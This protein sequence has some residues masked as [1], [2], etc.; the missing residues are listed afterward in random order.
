MSTSDRLALR[1]LRAADSA[2]T[3]LYGWR[4]NPLHQSGALAVIL[5]ALLIGTGLFLLFFY[6]VSQPWASVAVLQGQPWFGRWMRSLHRVAS[7]AL[8]LAVIVHA[9]R[10][11]AQQRA[12]GPRALAWTSGVVLLGIVFVS[13]WTGYVLV[14]DSFGARLAVSGAQLFDALPV[15]SEPT[16]RIFAG[17]EPVPAAF[18]FINLFLHIALPLGA[19][20]GLWIHLSRLARPTLAPPRT[21][22]I[23][24]VGALT[25]LAVLL[26]LP[27]DG[28]AALLTVPASVS[29][30]AFYA[31]WMPWAD[32]LSP[33]W[34]WTGALLTLGLA[35]AVP[36]FTRR[37]REGAWAPSVV[38]PKLCT[39]C[40]QCPVDCPWD[41]ITMQPRADGRAGLV[42]QVDPARCVSCGICAGSCAPMGVGPLLRSG[43]DQLVA[44]RR[45]LAATTETTSARHVA[46][47]CEHAAPAHL[48]PLRALGADVR[49]VP[50]AGNVHSSVV[51]FELRAGA[52]GVILYS[53]APRDCRGREGPKWLHERMYNGREAELQPRVDI[54]RVTS[55]VMAPGDLEGTLDAYR[56]F[57]GLPVASDVLRPLWRAVAIAAAVIALLLLRAGTLMPVAG[58]AGVAVAGDHAVLRLSWSARPERIEQCRRLSDEEFNALPAHMR[59]RWSCEGR[60]AS[61]LLSARVDDR[62]VVS[63]T[64]RGGGLRHDRPLHLF[65]E[66][67][68]PAGAHRLAVALERIDVPHGIDTAS[69]ADSTTGSAGDNA[70]TSISRD[71]RESQERRVRRAEAL[72]PR[73]VLDTLVH[74]GARRVILVSYR[75]AER[76]LTLRSAP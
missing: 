12:W 54:S 26:P 76:R 37:P 53:C 15:L 66:Y 14:W 34:A 40:N 74:I 11:F 17:D 38:D 59:M 1:W 22:I 73:I 35:A 46:I 2:A 18:F 13:G 69:T 47:C 28:E 36:R 57:T 39:G 24:V 3:R 63:D 5:L 67:A 71:A 27:L 56:R 49:L 16:R 33:V 65:R 72:P 61:Y 21:L 44:L 4:R 58:N 75:D 42:A 64:V 23:A 31:F 43:R 10:M 62:L 51:E 70:A 7:D 6:R 68:L 9:W 48:D 32:A 41:A 45:T 55:A 50:C 29:M 8:V 52:P 20:A 25:A 60:F 30:D 19:G